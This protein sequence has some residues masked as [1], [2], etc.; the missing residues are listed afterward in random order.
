MNVKDTFL[1]EYRRGF[2]GADLNQSWAK[3]KTSAYQEALQ[4]VPEVER[5]SRLRQLAF[6]ENRELVTPEE[7][8]AQSIA[9]DMGN[10]AKQYKHK[11]E[12]GQ[13]KRRGYIR[14]ESHPKTNGRDLL[15]LSSLLPDPPHGDNLPT[16]QQ[17]V[18]FIRPMKV[19]QRAFLLGETPEEARKLQTRMTKA[20][21][22]AGWGMN[23]EKPYTGSVLE[24][25]AMLGGKEYSVYLFARVR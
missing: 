7:L 12:E 17:I 15:S 18:N 5:L 8:E 19:G 22:S 20:T 14:R 25:K 10:I 4:S 23:G 1:S 13:P 21:E 6:D 24:E 3:V 2:E 11:W 9:T 16:I